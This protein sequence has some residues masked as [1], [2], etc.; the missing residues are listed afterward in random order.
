MKHLRIYTPILVGL[1]VALL[2]GCATM[3]VNTAPQSEASSLIYGHLNKEHLKYSSVVFFFAPW[4]LA[5]NMGW[6]TADDLLNMSKKEKKAAAKALMEEGAWIYWD[7]STSTFACPVE[8]PGDYY[9]IELDVMTGN[10]EFLLYS[11]L[12]DRENTIKVEQ[13]GMYY[14]GA[15]KLESGDKNNGYALVADP[16][17]TQLDVLDGVARHLSGKGWDAW[18]NRERAYLQ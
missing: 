4:E 7:R 8:K 18:I 9:L 16:S 6:N 15:C 10:T 11:G 3:G 5:N 14:W 12:P 17:V 2:S 13:G 1:T